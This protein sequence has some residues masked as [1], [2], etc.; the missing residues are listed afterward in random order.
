[1]AAGRH[2][3]AEG[4]FA[5]EA[6]CQ[7]L[8]ETIDDEEAVVDRDAETDEGHEVACPV[9]EVQDVC[10]GARQREAA[11]DAQQADAQR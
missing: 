1:M 9:G 7:F 2:G 8:A 5:V 3:A 4:V 11:R 6:V 10:Q